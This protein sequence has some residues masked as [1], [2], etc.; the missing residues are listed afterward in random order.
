MPDLTPRIRRAALAAKIEATYGTN[1]FAGAP[2]A[3]DILP[4]LDIEIEEPRGFYMNPTTTGLLDHQPGVAG[5]LMARVRGAIWLRGAGEAYSATNKPAASPILR[6]L[7]FSEVVVTTPGLETVTYKFPKVPE[8][9]S[10]SLIFMQENAPSLTILGTRGTGSLVMVA[11][12]PVVLRFELWGI[13]GG[14][15]TQALVTAAP[16]QAPIH[17]ILASA[18]FQ[19][20]TENFAAQF[21]ALTVALNSLVVPKLDPNN[22]NA[23]SGMFITT[24]PL[25]PPAIEFDPEAVAAATYDWFTKWGAGTLIDWSL[26]TNGAQYVRVKFGEAANAKAQIA[27]LRWGSRDELR[28]T[29]VTLNLLPNAGADALTILFD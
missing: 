11:G 28:T 9:D 10:L 19:I 22:V 25:R 16:E 6:A 1:A 23:Y 24:D 20:G 12:Q 15:G 3:A 26:Q 2:V 29:P 27:S 7:G 14:R 5:E 4:V 17:P 18:A 13:H 21:R 8:H